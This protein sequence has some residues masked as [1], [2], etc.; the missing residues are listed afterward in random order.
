MHRLKFKS[1]EF[2]RMLTHMMKH[3]RKI[4]Y[5]N[6][7]TDDYGLWLVKDNGI[8]VMSPSAKR[9]MDGEG[10]HV[11]YAKG[12]EKTNLTFGTRLTRLVVTILRSLFH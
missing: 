1:K 12:Y 10:V 4:P 2:Q 9:D 3:D 11:I 5:E 6:E 7:T 8:Y